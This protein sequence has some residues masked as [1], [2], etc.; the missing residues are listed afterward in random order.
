MAISD[1]PP[2]LSL[3]GTTAQMEYYSLRGS[4]VIARRQL[5][6]K[7]GITVRALRIRITRLKPS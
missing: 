6:Q 2:N 5:A 1:C 3:S 7:H 4:R